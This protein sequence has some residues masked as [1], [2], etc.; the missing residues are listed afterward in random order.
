[1]N[2]VQIR[3]GQGCLPQALPHTTSKTFGRTYVLQWR[4][5]GVH[6]QKVYRV[7]QK[8]SAQTQVTTDAEWRQN[9]QR[10]QQ[11]VCMSS[12]RQVNCHSVGPQRSDPFEWCLAAPTTV[13]C[14]LNRNN[15]SSLLN[16]FS[17]TSA[18]LVSYN[19]STAYLKV[20]YWLIGSNRKYAIQASK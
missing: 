10:F 13:L 2:T 16:H 7:W 14:R 9:Q 15:A 3:R 4:S 20:S 18:K 5:G 17:P 8:L 12:T 11:G 19:C 1:M 6:Y